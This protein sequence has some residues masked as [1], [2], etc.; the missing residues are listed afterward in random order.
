[1]NHHAKTNYP[2]GKAPFIPGL[3][4][5]TMCFTFSGSTCVKVIS[6]SD[7]QVYF[8]WDGGRGPL[9]CMHV[10]RFAESFTSLT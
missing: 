1:M 7:G 9:H 2:A 6:Q 10:S 5:G 3:E 8:K 4:P